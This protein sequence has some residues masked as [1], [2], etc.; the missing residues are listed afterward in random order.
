MFYA[1]STNKTNYHFNF[2]DAREKQYAMFRDD[3]S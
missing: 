3:F 2:D 1:R